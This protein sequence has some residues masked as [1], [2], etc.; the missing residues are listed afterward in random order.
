M[1]IASNGFEIDT[2]GLGAMLGHLGGADGRVRIDPETVEQD[3]A[4]L[5]LALMEF[6]RQLM[7]LQAIRRMENGSL[8]PQ[9]EE[10]L[11]STLQRA[12]QAIHDMAGRFGL[13]PSDLSLDLGPLGRTV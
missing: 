5:V 2:E 8:S 9:Q 13:S 4:R 7:E 1:M 6:L 12:E 3:L 10:A 11:G